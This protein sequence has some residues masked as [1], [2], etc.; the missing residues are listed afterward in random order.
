LTSYNQ[1]THE[2]LG[3]SPAETIG[4]P[5][6][7]FLKGGNEEFRRIQGALKTLDRVHDF[8][9]ELIGKGQRNV[10][11]QLSACSLKDEKGHRI[12]IIAICRDLSRVRNLE[13]EIRQKDRFCASV[14][15]DSTDAIFTLDSKERITSWNKG[16]EAIFGYTEE[17]MLGRSFE[18]LLPDHLSGQGELEKI[19]KIAS[20]EGLLRSYQTQRLTKDGRLIDVLFTRTAI[21]DD[22]GNLVGF[23]S[24]LKD[25]TE[26]KLIDRHMV[27]MEKLSAI[28]ELAAGLAHEIKN[29]LAGIKGAIEVIRDTMSEEN[30]HR[31]ILREVLSEVSRIDRCVLN[32]LS[33]AKPK[34]PEFVETNPVGLIRDVLSFI[35]KVADAKGIFLNL[36]LAGEIPPVTGDE[37]DLKQLFMNL[38]LNSIEA[39]EEKGHVWITAKVTAGLR[40][41]VEISDDGP[42]IPPGRLDKIFQPFYTSKKQ[43]TGLGLATCKRIVSEHGGEIRVESEVGCGTRVVIDLPLSSGV[44]MSLA[45]R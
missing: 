24:V 31:V 42:G 8:E 14:L 11:V 26:Q 45:L 22:Q 4:K 2:L 5:L 35:H 28:G 25:I 6:Q 30:P 34:R 32:L 21:K 44:P 37:N 7:D 40:L 9:T 20:S 29:P 16:A 1:G 18:V 41:N 33:Y 10:P 36:Q 38:I 12:G 23:S 19:S 15:R 43:G 39:I 13:A 17:E 3:Y 27:Q